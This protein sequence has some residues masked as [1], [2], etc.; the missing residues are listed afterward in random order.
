MADLLQKAGRGA[1]M[2]NDLFS[3]NK[4]F[5]EHFKAK[6]LYKQQNVL[7]ILMREY[8]YSEEEARN[9]AKKEMLDAEKGLM[10]EYK[11]WE[12]RYS[13][14][15]LELRKYLVL[16]I[17]MCGGT[18]YWS[19]HAPRYHR[20]DLSTTSEDRATIIGRSNHGLRFLAN[21]PPPAATLGNGI[22]RLQGLNP[23]DGSI[24]QTQMR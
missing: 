16:S 13:D 21:Y 4:E 14:Q 1:I 17:L 24:D 9:I 22:L 23:K 7:A 3:F 6:T 20:T 15:S 8:G 19:S 2:M 5:D 18:A 10:Q 12:R 11:A